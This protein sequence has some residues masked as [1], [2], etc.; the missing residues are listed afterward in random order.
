MPVFSHGQDGSKLIEDLMTKMN[1][2]KDYSVNAKIK[3]DIPLI[4]ILSVNA[5]IYFKQKDKFRIISKGIAILPKQGFTDITKILRE[6]D[7]YSS[8]LT[9]TEIIQNTKTEIITILPGADTSDLILAK[10]WIDASNNLMLKSQITTR[11]SGTVTAEYK[12]STQKEFGLPE[13]ML[14]TMDVKK[15]KIPKGLA[16]D[17]NRTSGADSNKPVPKVGTVFIQLNNYVIN[18]GINDDIFLQK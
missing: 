14:F 10:L 1:L 13:S 17:I 4:K 3:S 18:K 2:V 9:G 8:I 7:T 15:F 11:S 5:T 6:K 16:T 12:Y